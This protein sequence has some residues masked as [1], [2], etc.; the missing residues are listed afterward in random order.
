MLMDPVQIALHPQFAAYVRDRMPGCAKVDRIMRGLKLFGAL[1][2]VA[3]SRALTWGQPPLVLVAD[4]WDEV[5][6]KP[7]ANGRFDPGRPGQVEI[8]E[9]RVNQFE[10][11]G[12]GGT[13]RNAKGQK[14][15][16]VGSTLLHELCHWG[17]HHAGLP[18]TSEAGR[19]FERFVYGRQIG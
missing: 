8:A 1:D 11:P 19:A 9:H 2:A 16:I 4:L 14:V 12:A 3:A 13:D 7:E 6:W 15:F 5:A 17:L 10:T 18:E